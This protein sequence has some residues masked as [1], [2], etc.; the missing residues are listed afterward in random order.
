MKSVPKIS[1]QTF[2]DINPESLSFQEAAEWVI[3]RVFDKGSL[4][5]VLQVRDYYG[6]ELVKET[7]TSQISILPRH[8]ILL[9]K[10]LFQL[11]FKDFKCLEKKPFQTLFSVE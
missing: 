3:L 10:A 8:S 7:L 5:E 4:Q 11:S 2:W 9:A 1:T 6:S